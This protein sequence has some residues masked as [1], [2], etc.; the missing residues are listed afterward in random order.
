MREC[1]SY[2]LNKERWKNP[3]ES[4]EYRVWGQTY[5]KVKFKDVRGGI[6][7]ENYQNP[8]YWIEDYITKLEN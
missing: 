2:H 7:K 8:D 4:K 3:T 6:E 5:L 1:R